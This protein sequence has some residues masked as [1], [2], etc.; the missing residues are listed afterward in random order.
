MIF[1][2]FILVN[3]LLMTTLFAFGVY[4][5]LQVE[6]KRKRSK[7]LI[8]AGLDADELRALLSADRQDEAIIR[9]MR[10]ADVDRFTAESALTQ[11]RGTSIAK[12]S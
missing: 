4:Q 3:L 8:D 11:L 6:E 10:A 2:L 12:E 7:L 5:F 1:V 9:L